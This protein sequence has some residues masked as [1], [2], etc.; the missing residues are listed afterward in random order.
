MEGCGVETSRLPEQQ[1][2][3]AMIKIAT[4]ELSRSNLAEYFRATLNLQNPSPPKTP[5]TNIIDF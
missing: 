1:T 2:Y 5:V 3:D 4:H